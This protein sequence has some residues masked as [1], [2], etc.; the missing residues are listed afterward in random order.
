MPQEVVQ[1]RDGMFGE[2][3]ESKTGS[4]IYDPCFALTRRFCLLVLFD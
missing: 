1:T 3:D 2:D 4:T